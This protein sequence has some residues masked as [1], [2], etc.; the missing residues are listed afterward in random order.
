VQLVAA[1][2]GL[3]RLDLLLAANRFDGALL[4]SFSGALATPLVEL[5]C[6]GLGA[7][8][9][10]GARLD[11]RRA[12]LSP[13]VARVGRGRATGLLASGALLEPGD[14]LLRLGADPARSPRALALV[15]SLLIPSGGGARGALA[16]ERVAFAHVMALPDRLEGVAAFRERRPPRFDW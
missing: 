10:D 5:A 2:L 12:L 16:K 11:F 8:W 9:P 3:T 7:T 14:V 1:P 13:L 15:R 4:T 6:L